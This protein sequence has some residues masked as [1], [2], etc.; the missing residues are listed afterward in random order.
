MT[1]VPKPDRSKAVRPTTSG[2]KP[3]RPAFRE[4]QY[5]SE[6][7]QW[8]FKLLKEFN[9]AKTSVNPTIS[10]SVVF[11]NRLG[12]NRFLLIPAAH[13]SQDYVICECPP[14]LPV[15]A[16]LSQ[17]RITGRR[18]VFYDHWEII[19]DDIAYEKMKIPIEPEIDFNDFQDELFLQW[20][21]IDSPLRELLAFEFVS[22]PPLLDFGQVGGLNFTLYD[23][24]ATGESK[25]LLKYFKGMIPLDIALGKSGS[26]TLLE[27]GTNHTLSP[28][29]GGSGVLTPTSL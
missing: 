3:I 12:K 15:P 18:S 2:F 22:S 14:G 9:Y 27:L 13:L 1:S 26:L 19:V 8:E 20:G 25:K 21:G 17:V 16:N 11:D 7:N 4:R 10:G 24:T 5:G 6:F 23:G 29:L 28:F